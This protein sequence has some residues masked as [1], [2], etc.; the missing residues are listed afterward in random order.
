M[1]YTIKIISA[2]KRHSYEE[3]VHLLQGFT[4]GELS[5]LEYT[6]TRLV[7]KHN[8]L[9]AF[10]YFINRLEDIPYSLL[11]RLLREKHDIE[12]TRITLER[13][14]CLELVQDNS[15]TY[16]IYGQILA[17]LLT[18][19]INVE[20][21]VEKILN[22]KVFNFEQIIKDDKFRVN[23]V[24]ILLNNKFRAQNLK[25][26][27]DFIKPYYI[28]NNIRL[29][30]LLY[31]ILYKFRHLKKTFA[32]KQFGDFKGLLD[33]NYGLTL[34][35]KKFEG[36]FGYGEDGYDEE[37]DLTRPERLLVDI[38]DQNMPPNISNI[39]LGSLLM[40]FNMDTDYFIRNGLE[41]IEDTEDME[42]IKEFKKYFKIKDIK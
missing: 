23:F 12:F 31:V 5:G 22:T 36:Y 6:I 33:L 19:H 2:I 8:N 11:R 29:E 39:R 38:I 30:E 4:N 18:F 16:K 9:Q 25:T 34:S 26:V 40:Y 35:N 42:K 41:F 10:K 28:K 7:F 15:K 24:R 14:E 17:S 32:L 20:D 37:E 13:L 1:K 21:L 27:I 3:F